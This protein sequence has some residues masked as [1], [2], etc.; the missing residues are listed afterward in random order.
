MVISGKNTMEFPLMKLLVERADIQTKKMSEKGELNKGESLSVEDVVQM[1]CE[2][3]NI[4]WDSYATK[5]GL[6]EMPKGVS[7]PNKDF[8]AVKSIL[9]SDMEYTTGVVASL[10][11]T[12][13]QWL[14]MSLKDAIDHAQKGANPEAGSPKKALFRSA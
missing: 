13:C 4:G 1:E 9:A 7:I 10:V 5:S 11:A 12:T 6:P 3:I 14:G 8:F 2:N